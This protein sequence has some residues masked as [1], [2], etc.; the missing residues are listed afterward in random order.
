M[1]QTGGY[2]LQMTTPT[3]RMY[4]Y[5]DSLPSFGFELVMSWFA[6]E[7]KQFYLA[8]TTLERLDEMK[9]MHV[10]DGVQ[11]D[12]SRLQTIALIWWDPALGPAVGKVMGFKPSL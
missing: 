5:G 11:P 12:T 4:S 6:R 1:L 10:S 9:A 3:G 7:L 8:S 2:N